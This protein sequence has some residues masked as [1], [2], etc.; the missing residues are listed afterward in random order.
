MWDLCTR[1]SPKM[2]SA[3]AS[4]NLE[5]TSRM[6]FPEDTAIMRH[7]SPIAFPGAIAVLMSILA[8]LVSTPVHGLVS[9]VEGNKPLRNV[10]DSPWPGLLAVFDDVSRVLYTVGPTTEQTAFY[11]GDTT[12]LERVLRAFAAV[13][14]EERVV[15][16]LPGRGE[17]F[18]W[19]KK[20]SFYDWRLEANRG[21]PWIQVPEKDRELILPTHPTLTVFVGGPIDLDKLRIPTGITLVGIDTLRARYRQGLLNRNNHVR[22]AAAWRIAQLDPYGDESAALVERL[23]PK[24][25]ARNAVKMALAEFQAR[26]EDPP[27]VR[28]KYEEEVRR[29]RHF[30]FAWR[31]P[32]FEAGLRLVVVLAAVL[33]CVTIVTARARRSRQLREPNSEADG[34]PAGS[35]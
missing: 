25:K 33:L 8:V 26:R 10:D 23:P 20:D 14:I 21:N 3:A 35:E 9:L 15:I 7:R 16:L 17:G 29:I 5:W 1:I 28:A 27:Q 13:K 30:I 18:P 6:D 12:V 2:L 34:L 4:Y 24:E 19:S 22:G 11:Q 31:Y 32:W